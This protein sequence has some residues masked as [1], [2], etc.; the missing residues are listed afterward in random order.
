MTQPS[1]ERIA[2]EDGIIALLRPLA[3]D[4]AALGL[5]DDCAALMP[6]PGT[7]VVLKT[8]PIAEGVHFLPD[9]PPEDIAW[10]ALAVNVSDLAAKAA[11]PLGYLMALSFPEAPRRE[12]LMRFTA[13][14]QQAQDAFG[15]TLLGGDTDRRPGPIT[16]SI[17]VLGEVP[18]GQMVRR[19]AARAGDR[20]FVSGTLG[21]AH[22]GLQL[23]R[24]AS[25]AAMWGLDDAQRT[26]L[27]QR[28]RRPQPRLAVCE[29]LRSAARAAMDLSDGL[30]KDLGRMARGSGT[31]AVI[32][33]DSVPLSEP[34]RAAVAAAPDLRPALLTSGDDYEVLAAVAPEHAAEFSRLA[35]AAGI[36][37]TDIGCMRDPEAEPVVVLDA[38]SRPLKIGRSGWDHF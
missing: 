21:D 38:Q 8:D 17:T 28:Y 34:A 26:F 30:V 15:F 25:Q 19:A 2:G 23:L 35:Q 10:K 12:W 31:S 36:P 14:L 18:H 13:G 16:I 33:L 1:D 11:Q 32:H 37:V 7:D 3:T 9:D 22:L 20:L 5:R 29:A 6:R 24:S 4:P 27:Q